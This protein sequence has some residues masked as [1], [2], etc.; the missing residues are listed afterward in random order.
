VSLGTSHFITQD[1]FN[2]N[3]FFKNNF[4][5]KSNK[6]RYTRFNNLLVN[7]DYKTGHYVG[8]WDQQ[9]PY[10]YSSFI[11]VARGIRKPS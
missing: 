9:Y 6:T 2:L 10:L 5:E 1:D 8:S 3:N 7:Y 4:L 11:E